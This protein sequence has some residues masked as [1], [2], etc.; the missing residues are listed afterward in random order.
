MDPDGEFWNV[1]AGAGLGAVFGEVGGFI[2]S[3]VSQKLGGGK[4]NVR[5]SITGGLINAVS[6][7]IY[8][9]RMPLSGVPL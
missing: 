7:A 6:N 2:S 3:A 9:K 4:V 5:E 8:G 1:V